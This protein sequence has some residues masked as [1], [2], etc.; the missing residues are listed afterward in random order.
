MAENEADWDAWKTGK[1]P[2]RDGQGTG[3]GQ[4]LWQN[5]HFIRGKCLREPGRAKFFEAQERPIKVRAKEP[6]KY[7]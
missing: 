7:T 4:A 1:F 5:V 3:L 6:Y 2:L